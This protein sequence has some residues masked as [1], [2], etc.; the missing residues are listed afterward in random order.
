MDKISNS[1]TV[2]FIDEAALAGRRFIAN[3]ESLFTDMDGEAVILS[4]QNGKYYGVNAVGAFIWEM[5][6]KPV[7]FEDIR[8][9]A[10]H[11][12]E[13]DENTCRREIL[14]FLKKMSEEGLIEILDGKNF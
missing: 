6:Q 2:Q 12:Y 14:A 11:E 5:L 13:I 7:S 3:K 8:S 9:T 10:M 1:T 4:L